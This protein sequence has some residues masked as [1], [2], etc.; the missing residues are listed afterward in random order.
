MIIARGPRASGPTFVSDEKTLRI[1]LHL[2]ST[3]SDGSLSPTDLVKAAGAGGLHVIALA[4]H[5]T[6]AGYAEAA[7]AAEGI[8]HVIPALEMSTMHEGS[9]VHVLGYFVD[10][11]DPTLMR[12]SDNAA[13]ARRARMLGMLD[14]LASLGIS[15]PFGDVEEVAGPEVRSMGR[16]HLAKALVQRGYASTFADA[17]DRYIG[18]SG[19]AYLPNALL[20]ACGAI[21][22][23]HEAGGLAVWAHPRA[24]MFE[25]DIRR[26]VTWGLDGVECYRPRC[27]PTESLRLET[28]TRELGLFVTGGSDWH[29]PWH[30]RLGAFAVTQEDVATFL[31]RG[32]I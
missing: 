4:D 20:T 5:D 18:D 27:D 10:P 28:V 11:A 31:E 3:A 25:R 13:E 29:G 2:H 26:F 17:F 30:G 8:L 15:V 24:D 22:L 7:V 12:Y 16:P 6:T 14:R 23:I 32:G 9:E 1:D 21:E 19:P